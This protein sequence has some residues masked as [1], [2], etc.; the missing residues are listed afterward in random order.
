MQSDLVRQVTNGQIQRFQK[1]LNLLEMKLDVS[2]VLVQLLLVR[3][4][5][6]QSIVQNMG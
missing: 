2:D 3:L 6:C 5:L 1:C 4:R